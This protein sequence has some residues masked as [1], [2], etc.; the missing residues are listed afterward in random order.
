MNYFKKG[1]T[2]LTLR[3]KCQ[4]FVPNKIVLDSFLAQSNIKNTTEF[5]TGFLQPPA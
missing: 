4:M 2:L 3:T 1:N 5:E